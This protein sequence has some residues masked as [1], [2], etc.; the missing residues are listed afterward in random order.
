MGKYIFLSLLIIWYCAFFAGFAF[1]QDC[2]YV[3]YVNYDVNGNIVNSKQ[4]YVCETP[5][6]IVEVH[7]YPNKDAHDVMQTKVYGLTLNSY[8]NPSEVL[9]NMQRDLEKTKNREKIQQVLSSKNMTSIFYFLSM[10]GN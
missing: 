4:E 9:Y 8:E 5:K 1:G 2:K 3:N 7:T 6:Q 10:F